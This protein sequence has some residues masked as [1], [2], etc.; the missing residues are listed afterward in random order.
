[1]LKRRSTIANLVAGAILATAVSHPAF[2]TTSLNASIWFPETQPL[3]RVGYVEWAKKVAAASNGDLN[4]KVFTDTTLLPVTAHLSGLRDGIVDITYHAGTYTPS[5]LPEDNVL[6]TLGINLDDTLETAFAV[7]DFYINDAQMQALFKRHKIVFLGAYSSI[8]Y[9]LICRQPVV[10]VADLQGKKLRTP[11]PI[12]SDWARS[13]GATP[14]SVPS[15]EMFTGLDKGQIDCVLMGINELKTRSLW[16]VAKNVNQVN[17]GPYYAGWQWAMNSNKWNKLSDEQRRILLDTIAESTVETELAY[18]ADGEAALQE[19]QQHNVTIHPETESLR[20]SVQNFEQTA[21]ASAIKDGKER[22]KLDD[23]EALID[24][25]NVTLEK[26][27]GLL[28]E[29]DRTDAAALT[30]VL[31]TNLYNNIDASTYGK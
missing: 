25:F 27:Q 5:E 3:A 8:P 31:K 29:V 28:A 6:A 26:W 13:V 16:D 14:V 4:I 15:S 10:D 22:F 7:A 30:D 12:H 18:I 20:A 24:R 17:L 23:P 21:R 11:G 9:N 19:A 1:M 2:A